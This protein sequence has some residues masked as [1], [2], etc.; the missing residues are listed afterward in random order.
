MYLIINLKLFLKAHTYLCNS[1]DCECRRKPI[2][3]ENCCEK[4]G[5]RFHGGRCLTGSSTNFLHCCERQGGRADC[6]D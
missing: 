5:G 3:T 4:T 2:W 1:P 6:V